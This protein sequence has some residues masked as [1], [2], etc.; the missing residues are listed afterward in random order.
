MGFINGN[1]NEF[2]IYLTDKGKESFYNGGLKNNA[3]YF[4]LSDDDTNYNIL[5]SDQFNPSLT[6]Q[7][8]VTIK[9]DNSL[10]N[11]FKNVFTQSSERGDILS[12]SEYK[13]GLF[14]INKTTNRDYILYSPSP[15]ISQQ[16]PITYKKINGYKQY[17]LVDLNGLYLRSQYSENPK[18]GDLIQN[19]DLYPIDNKDIN[20]FVFINSNYQDKT[21]IFDLSFIGNNSKNRSNTNVVHSEILK[22]NEL[23]IG[24]AYHN[25]FN[26]Y[27]RFANAKNLKYNPTGTSENLSVNLFVL[28]GSNKIPLKL[29]GLQQYRT[30]GTTNNYTSG[31]IGRYTS[32]G[33]TNLVNLVDDSYTILMNYSEKTYTVGLT[34]HTII[35]HFDDYSSAPTGYNFRVNA[36]LDFD[37]FNNN[38]VRN[39]NNYSI[40]VEY[41]KL[42]NKI[43]K[44]TTETTTYYY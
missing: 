37:K 39:N 40:L 14:G 6:N 31:I 20:R 33:Y 42:S 12:G 44:K 1:T 43:I 9:D 15:T 27:F 23:V 8:I 35:D 10:T 13:N 18:L 24:E 22:L 41:S 29:S 32:T 28:L 2:V 26:F 3:L 38:N 17:Y 21:N 11:G 36:K 5:N 7:N 34:E 30:T 19:Y 4:S 16:T 25:S